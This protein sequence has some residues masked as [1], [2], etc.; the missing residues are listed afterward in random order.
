MRKHPSDLDDVDE[1]AV[2][3]M[4]TTVVPEDSCTDDLD[5]IDEDRAPDWEITFVTPGADSRTS[6]LET[7]RHVRLVRGRGGLGMTL[8]GRNPVKIQEIDV[9]G[10][11]YLA[12]LRVGDGIRAVDGRE[13]S[14][15]DHAQV[16][17]EA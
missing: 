8:L 11:A 1:Y 9:G 10:P 3:L 4:V 16:R 12:G 14:N 7:T 15:M 13:C 5:G 6:K 2:T 17:T